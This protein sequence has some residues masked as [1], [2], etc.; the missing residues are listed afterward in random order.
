MTQAPRFM[1]MTYVFLE[2]LN[3]PESWRNYYLSYRFPLIIC[4]LYKPMFLLL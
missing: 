2:Q 3:Y 4:P 1:V